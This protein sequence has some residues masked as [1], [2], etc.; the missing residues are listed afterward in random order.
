MTTHAPPRTEEQRMAALRYANE[1]RLKRA[2]LKRE[3]KEGSVSA[4][5]VILQ[6]PPYVL[7]MRVV[8]LLVASPKL[9]KVKA[10]RLI[11]Y[12]RISPSKT[13]GG[14]STRQRQE[15]IRWLR[16][17]YPGAAAEAA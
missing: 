6:P 1:I 11:S 14:M 10:H 16:D 5:A 13:L 3:L 7:T 2:A 15:L 8:D 4:I 12:C 9:G 17:R